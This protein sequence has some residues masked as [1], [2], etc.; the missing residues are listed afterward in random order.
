LHGDQHHRHATQGRVG[1][2]RHS[3]LI[4]HCFRADDDPPAPV[5]CDVAP[6]DPPDADDEP[7]TAAVLPPA[8]PLLPAF[9]DAEL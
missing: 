7:P 3:S 8:A 4:T 2:A 5:L 9:P 6:P 1:P